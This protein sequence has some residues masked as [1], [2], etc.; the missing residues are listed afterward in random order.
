LFTQCK[1]AN[2]R[3]SEFEI[4]DVFTIKMDVPVLSMQDIH[5]HAAKYVT[6][7]DGCRLS[8]N[9]AFEFLECISFIMQKQFMDKLR[10][11]SFHS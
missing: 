9:H 4:D 2:A 11:S 3:I 1:K 5:N 6:V 10:R 8:R 7:P